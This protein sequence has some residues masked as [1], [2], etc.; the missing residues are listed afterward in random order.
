VLRLLSRLC[1]KAYKIFVVLHSALLV[2]ELACVG[3]EVLVI[4]GK[5]IFGETL[6]VKSREDITGNAKSL[7][8]L[9]REGDRG[10]LLL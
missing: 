8:I 3:V 2:S 9:F 7:E 6:T 1:A 10:I 5:G 4:S